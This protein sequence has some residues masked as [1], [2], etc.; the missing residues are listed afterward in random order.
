ML[1]LMYLIF[2][3]K[4]RITFFYPLGR[5]RVEQK[6][7]TL[8]KIGSASHWV[9]FFFVGLVK[10]FFWLIKMDSV[11]RFLTF[12][13]KKLNPLYEQSKMVWWNFLF[14]RT[15]VTWCQHS[16]WLCR[17]DVSVVNYYADTMSVKS[18]TMLPYGKLFY[19]GKSKKL[20]KKVTKNVIW[21][22]RKLCVHEGV[23]YADTVSA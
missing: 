21:Y 2:A 22:F 17:H 16:Q 3:K 15:M 9:L 18:T 5:R 14:V 1:S 7:F 4:H 6:C 10:L 23:D 13:C 20:K 19:F 11:T 12:F 8:I